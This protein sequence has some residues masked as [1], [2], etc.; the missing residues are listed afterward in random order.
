A[1]STGDV[2]DAS[3]A[4]IAQR[5]RPPAFNQLSLEFRE[6]G[7]SY[8][9]AHPEGVQR[10]LNLS[11]THAPIQPPA[12][13]PGAGNDGS[14]VESPRSRSSGPVPD[15]GQSARDNDGPVTFARLESLSV[16]TLLLTGD[17]DLYLPPSVLRLFKQHIPTAEIHVISESGH[18]AYW[19][20]PDEFNRRVLE[21]LRGH[22]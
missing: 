6:L 5:L 18:A 14:A 20:N 4:E 9:A 16:P 8:R 12:P 13:A 15:R 22:R 21:F 17:A 3:Y 7:P 11:Q 2:Q 1:N 10:W 19:E